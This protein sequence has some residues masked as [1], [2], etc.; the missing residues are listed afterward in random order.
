V[1]V[2][3]FAMILKS[4]AKTNCR[5]FGFRD[6]FLEQLNQISL[7]SCLHLHCLKKWHLDVCWN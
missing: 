6:S 2:L 7:W 5:I 1:E 4:L 3:T